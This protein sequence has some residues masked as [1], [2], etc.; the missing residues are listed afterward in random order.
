MTNEDKGSRG[1]DNSINTVIM[2]T[3]KKWQRLSTRELKKKKKVGRND[4]Q[5]EI[6][7]GRQKHLWKKIL[8]E[9]KVA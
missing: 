7:S 9:R 5:K 1:K 6:E 8:K 4:C 3:K 2:K